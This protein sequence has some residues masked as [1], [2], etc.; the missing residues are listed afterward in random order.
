MKTTKRLL[1]IAIAALAL[2]AC[3]KENSDVLILEAE[4]MH[5]GTKMAID[6]NSSYWANGDRVRLKGADDELFDLY[7]TYEINLS[8]SGQATIDLGENTLRTPIC[9]VY[10]ASL[11]PAH[12]NGNNYVVTLPDSYQYAITYVNSVEK[13]NL[14]SP[15][16][17][18]TESGNR[19]RFKHLT[20]AVTVEITNDFGIDVIV[21]DITVS[22]N[23]YQL[24]GSRTIDIT[25]ITR[26]ATADDT[27]QT[28]DASE[29]QVQMTFDGYH[30]LIIPSGQ[31]KQ[32]QLPVLPVGKLNKF[33]VSVTV[34]NKDD[35]DMEYTFTKEQ[36]H[37][38]A[39]LR[40]QIGYAPAKFGAKFAIYP[41]GYVRFAPGNLQ[42][43][44]S[45][46][47]WRFAKHQ[48]D[49]IGNAAGNNTSVDRNIQEGWIDL[50]GYGTS[51]WNIDR[52]AYPAY[53]PW[54]TSTDNEDYISWNLTT[55]YEKTDWGVNDISNGMASWRTT[56][57][58]DII[59]RPSNHFMIAIVNGVNG[60]ILY[61]DEYIHPLEEPLNYDGI[62]DATEWS[63]MEVAGAIFLPFTGKRYGT[64]VSEVGEKGYYWTSGGYNDGTAYV[65][66]LTSETYNECSAPHIDVSNGFSVRLIRVED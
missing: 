35:A 54:A 27:V 33:T 53:Q 38:N 17:A 49:I 24:C 25:D 61:T 47:I 59:T 19:L 52:E 45:T 1:A 62:F 55:G 64:T 13:Q 26:D 60:L 11:Y 6:G 37:S 46:G 63:K 51:G 23:L 3:Q 43:Q 42:Y 10:P 21:T 31:T 40:A 65:T 9:G 30:Q 41:D 57:L 14:Q 16:M 4:G 66:I 5:N 15:M 12:L 34:Q 8:V 7:N 39:L 28:A 50:F 44:A 18:Y 2:G 32:V 29:R 20:S 58:S 48:Y 56:D 22:S 36:A